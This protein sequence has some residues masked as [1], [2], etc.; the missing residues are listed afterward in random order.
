MFCLAVL[1]APS[2]AASAHVLR[3]RA[4]PRCT[5]RA[6]AVRSD[7]G[8]FEKSFKDELYKEERLEKN[9]AVFLAGDALPS[10]LNGFKAD[11]LALR[12]GID[13]MREA[14]AN[15]A[16]LRPFIEALKKA[17]PSLVT[18]VDQAILSG[19]EQVVEFSKP[20]PARPPPDS[21]LTS[22]QFHALREASMSAQ[23]SWQQEGTCPAELRGPLGGIKIFFSLLRNPRTEPTPDVW[24]CVRSQ[25]PILEGVPD[26]ELQKNL[27]EC[28]KELVDA[29]QL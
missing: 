20:Q 14:G 4:V 13:D 23:D 18:E 12:Q 7:F 15:V 28:R 6:P 5:P 25:W 17:S 21:Y 26:E 22:E 19:A 29:R 9:R 11:G 24:R 16:E 8:S 27:V 1:A 2:V 10:L 3:A